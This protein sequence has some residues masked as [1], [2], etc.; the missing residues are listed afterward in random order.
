MSA[1]FWGSKKDNASE[2]SREVKDARQVERGR[3]DQQKGRWFPALGALGHIKGRTHPARRQ[4]QELILKP[5][6]CL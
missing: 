5:F 4:G 6:L 2:G 3:V 1:M